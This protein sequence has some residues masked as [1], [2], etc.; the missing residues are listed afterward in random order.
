MQKSALSAHVLFFTMEGPIILSPNL[1]NLYNR[2]SRDGFSLSVPA[3][4]SRGD[5]NLFELNYGMFW[6]YVTFGDSSK[7]LVEC[8]YADILKPTFEIRAKNSEAEWFGKE[9]MFVTGNDYTLWRFDNTQDLL[10]AMERRAEI[11]GK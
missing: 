11:V 6:F 4:S 8:N 3:R 9:Y 1:S 7:V 2:L 10:H 5:L